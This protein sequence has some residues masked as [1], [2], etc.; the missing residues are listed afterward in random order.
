LNFN[1][2]E[3]KESRIPS[4]DQFE[5]EHCYSSDP[6]AWVRKITPKNIFA[7]NLFFRRTKKKKKQ[8]ML[9]KTTIRT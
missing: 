1:K 8:R 4:F 2:R 7:K 5:V 6:I 3:K 9:T